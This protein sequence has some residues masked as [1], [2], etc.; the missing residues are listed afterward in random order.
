M[1]ELKEYNQ[2][3]FLI[4]TSDIKRVREH[5]DPSNSNVKSL[6]RTSNDGHIMCSNTY[7][8]IAQKLE[9]HERKLAELK[10]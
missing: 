6:I 9:D 1:I 7:E 4:R 3:R 5:A 10:K 2:V 8:E